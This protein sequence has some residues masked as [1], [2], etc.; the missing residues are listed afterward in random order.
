M[1]VKTL[2]VLDMFTGHV[3]FRNATICY[4]ASA[5][6]LRA[7]RTITKEEKVGPFYGSAVFVYVKRRTEDE[8]LWGGIELRD[9]QT[10]RRGTNELLEKINDKH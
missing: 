4:R 10:F 2:L 6:Y 9:F 8:N 3:T 1:D 5:L 7:T